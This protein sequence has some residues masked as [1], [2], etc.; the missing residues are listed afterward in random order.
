LGCNQLIKNTKSEALGQETFQILCTQLQIIFLDE[1]NN[2][3][4]CLIRPSTRL[5][6]AY[7]Q[8]EIT[9]AWEKK[10]YPSNVIGTFERSL[11]TFVTETLESITSNQPEVDVSQD[12]QVDTQEN[13]LEE[14]TQN[15]FNDDDELFEPDDDEY[16]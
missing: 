6:T 7:S 12:Q 15:F 3:E 16:S 8:G 1:N 4:Y 2:N 10:D 9:Q 14:Q 5:Y 11:S 13:G